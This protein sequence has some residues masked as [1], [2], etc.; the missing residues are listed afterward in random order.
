VFPAPSTGEPSGWA[1]FN[2]V[3]KEV[4][5]EAETVTLPRNYS[6]FLI[7]SKYR[8]DKLCLYSITEVVVF[9]DDPPN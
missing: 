7:I 1:L 4:F 2:T 3:M 9:I 6:L 8:F 5:G